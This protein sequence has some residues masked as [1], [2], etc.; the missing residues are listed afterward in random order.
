MGWCKVCVGCSVGLV[1]VLWCIVCVYLCG[2][3]S[4]S[5]DLQL[6]NHKVEINTDSQ[7]TVT[8]KSSLKALHTPTHTQTHTHTS[9]LS[10]GSNY[11]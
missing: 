2:S 1:I 3:G 10:V 5:T 8:H 4:L 11:F 7:I 9:D 6:S